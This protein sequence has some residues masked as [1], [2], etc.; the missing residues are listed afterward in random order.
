VQLDNNRFTG[1]LPGAWA[2]SQVQRLSLANNQLV[3]EAFPTPWLAPGAFPQL[4]DLALHDIPGLTG[5]LPASLSWPK[6]A[7]L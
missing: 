5:T 3:G 4:W 1:S 2:A 6:L 7:L